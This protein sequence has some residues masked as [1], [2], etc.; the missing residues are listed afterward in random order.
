MR[1]NLA[2]FYEIAES[3]LLDRQIAEIPQSLCYVA[4]LR[5]KGSLTGLPEALYTLQDVK[6]VV[7]CHT[8]RARVIL[9]ARRCVEIQVPRG[10][11][12]F[13]E[14]EIS[15]RKLF[16]THISIKTLDMLDHLFLWSVKLH[17]MIP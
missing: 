10:V 5:K 6:E 15:S 2:Q 14:D 8:L 11:G 17:S 16:G 12:W 13:L 3:A 7:E 9:T 1:R 4:A